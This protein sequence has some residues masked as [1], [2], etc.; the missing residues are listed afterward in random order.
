VGSFEGWRALTDP[1]V[2]HDAPRSRH[3]T[4]NN[5]IGLRC[6]A[7]RMKRTTTTVIVLG[8]HR[9]GTSC[10]TGSLQSAGL[11]LGE[12]ITEAPHNLKGNRENRSIMALNERVLT[13]SGGSWDAPPPE[14]TWRDSHR[15]ERDGIL[16]EYGGDALWGFKDPRTLLVL[17]GWLEVCVDVR[18][19]ATFRHPS[20]VARSL[21]RRNG[22]TEDEWVRL[23]AHYNE[24]LLSLHDE[25]AFPLVDFDLDDGDYQGALAAAARHLGLCGASE[26]PFYDRSLRH[27]RVGD[28]EHVPEAA[29]GIYTE[30]R[31]RAGAG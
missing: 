5:R 13:D 26:L 9:S 25:H 18:Y 28:D 16:A 6:H 1:W 4:Q 17:E 8:M 20:A 3:R 27:H 23:W 29:R 10:L 19:V 11:Y 12:V 22:R 30:L 21:M 7:E 15:E 14:V 2:V 31:R 24:R